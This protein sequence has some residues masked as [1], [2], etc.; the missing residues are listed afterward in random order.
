M[1]NPA[2][3]LR[4]VLCLTVVGLMACNTPV[5]GP[6][7]DSTNSAN[8]DNPPAG[9]NAELDLSF[10]TTANPWD[11]GCRTSTLAPMAG[12][13]FYL[14]D[15]QTDQSYVVGDDSSFGVWVPAGSFFLRVPGY[16]TYTFS[17]YKYQPHTGEIESTAEVPF[18]VEPQSPG[19]WAV[20]TIPIYAMSGESCPVQ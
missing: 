8:L 14:S 12:V 18:V 17:D 11:E 5:L 1:E 19:V 10:F 6:S 16:D 7:D 20:F 9:A 4:R 3:T 13:T 15:G 2:C